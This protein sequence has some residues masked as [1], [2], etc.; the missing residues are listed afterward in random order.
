[1]NCRELVHVGTKAAGSTVSMRVSNNVSATDFIP[2]F[3][4]P[5][6]FKEAP[7]IF[8]ML[9]SMPDYVYGEITDFIIILTRR[10]GINSVKADIA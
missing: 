4:D 3:T 7:D 1:M 5:S 8:T 9:P 10:L 2:G 6:R